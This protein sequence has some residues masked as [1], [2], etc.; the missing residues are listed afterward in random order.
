MGRGGREGLGG[1]GRGWE[2]RGGRRRRE[3]EEVGTPD[4]CDEPIR[5]LPRS[6]RAKDSDDIRHL[7]L[8]MSALGVRSDAAFSVAGR[9]GATVPGFQFSVTYR[10]GGCYRPA[11]QVSVTDRCL[12]G[13]A[14][15][16]FLPAP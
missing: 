1:K 14:V 12:M 6:P 10:A 11:F 4:R 8:T 2:G 15:S 9:E 5:D 13:V 7:A 16:A 3:E